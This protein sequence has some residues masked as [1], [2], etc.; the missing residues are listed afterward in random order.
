M[1][2]EYGY[3]YLLE[4]N[5]L[6]LRDIGQVI[7]AGEIPPESMWDLLVTKQRE[8]GYPVIGMG[9]HL[10]SLLIA[11]YGGHFLSTTEAIRLLWALKHDMRIRAAL[12]GISPNIK[13][14]LKLYPD[15]ILQLFSQMAEHG[16]AAVG[17]P[18]DPVVEMIVKSNIGG[19]VSNWWQC[20]FGRKFPGD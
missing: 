17:S 5:G 13:K 20:L 2:S 1:S 3:P 10:A 19:I 8:V 11:G 15:Q 7:F 9:E 6:N 14:V 18:S 12:D 16:F 4:R